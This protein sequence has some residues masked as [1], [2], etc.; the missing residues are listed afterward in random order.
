MATELQVV[1]SAPAFRARPRRTRDVS[2]GAVRDRTIILLGFLFV[3]ELASRLEIVNPLFLPPPTRILAAVGFV[4]QDPVFATAMRTTGYQILFAFL[5]ALILGGIVGVALGLSETLKAAYLGPILFILGT[6]K[7]VFLPIFMLLFGLGTPSKI[8]FGAFSAF[9]YVSTNIVG[10]VELLQAK[11]RRLAHAFQAPFPMYLRDIVL[12]AALPGLLAALW[13]GLRQSLTAVLVAEL[14]ASQNG[15]G[16]LIRVYTS[17]FNTDRTLALVLIVS[18]AAIF[19]AVFWDAL[20]RRMDRWRKD[21]H[22]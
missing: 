4:S 1:E 18:V 11:H 13:F 12:P 2:P 14:F 10:G 16:Y 22:T 6:P 5:I 21:S 9:F 8:A 3:W 7:S 15:I 17:Q 19:L 20:E